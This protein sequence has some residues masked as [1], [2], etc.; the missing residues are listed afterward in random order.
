LLFT[1]SCPGT[2]QKEVM[3]TRGSLQN[4]IPY[5]VDSG[6][7]ITPWWAGRRINILNA[8]VAD[9]SLECLKIKVMSLSGVQ[10]AISVLKGRLKSACFGLNQGRLF[11]Y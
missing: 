4:G 9:K 6:G 11:F 1:D 2:H 5:T 3:K 7:N 10:N 8:Q